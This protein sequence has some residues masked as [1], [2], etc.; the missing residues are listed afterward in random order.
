M[1]SLQIEHAVSDFDHWLAAFQRFSDARAEAGVKTYRVQRPVDDPN[2]VVI[3]LDFEGVEAA[4]RFLGFLRTT[5]WA[6]PEN[7]P[8]LVGAPRTRILE[9]APM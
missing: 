6:S 8:A 2:Y 9:A 4:Q 1:P 5:V 7:A 3:E